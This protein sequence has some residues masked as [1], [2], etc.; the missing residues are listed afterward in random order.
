ME[1]TIM[2][3]E[4]CPSINVKS[5]CSSLIKKFIGTRILEENSYRAERKRLKDNAKVLEAEGTPITHLQMMLDDIDRK[6]KALGVS[7][8]ILVEVKSEVSFEGTVREMAI[9]LKSTDPCRLKDIDLFIAFLH[10]QGLP[11][12]TVISKV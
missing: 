2:S 11:E 6:E 7:K 12:L 3:D 10:E 4:D 1:I 9:V 5:L 8:T